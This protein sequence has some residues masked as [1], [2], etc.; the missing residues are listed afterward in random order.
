MKKLL[1]IICMM[2]FLTPAFA[3]EQWRA[4][5]GTESI[6]GTGQ[7]ADIDEAVY[8]QIVAPLD[9]VLKN[10]IRGCTLIPASNSTLSVLAGEV[11]I[12]DSASSVTRLRSKSTTLTVAWTELDTGAEANSTQYY[13]Y[14]LADTLD[15]STYTACISTSATTPDSKTYYRL[16]GSFYNDASGNI[17]DVKPIYYGTV[18]KTDGTADTVNDTSYGSDITGMSVKYYASGKPVMIIYSAEL[19]GSSGTTSGVIDIDGT[20]KTQSERQYHLD[21]DIQVKVMSLLHA[22]T[23]TAGVHTITIQ[24]KVASGSCT[25]D[26]KTLVITEI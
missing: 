6:L 18:V 11:A 13:V 23:L 8:D 1:S 22:E 12:S 7:A 9:V 15:S 25:V 16:I 4:G 20:D 24:G 5:D 3:L 21:S 17:T 10:Y 2:C 14:L 26:D 19:G